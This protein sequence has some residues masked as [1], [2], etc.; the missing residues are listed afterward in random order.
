MIAPQN[1]VPK[2]FVLKPGSLV[3]DFPSLLLDNS[4]KSSVKCV[5]SGSIFIFMKKELKRF[6]EEYPSVYIMLKDKFLLY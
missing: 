3:G 1:K 4:T 5:D 2:N 6:L